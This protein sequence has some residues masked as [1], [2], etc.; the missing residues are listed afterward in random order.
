MTLAVAAARSAVLAAAG[1]S[2]NPF[3]AWENLGATATLGGTAVLAD[4]ARINAVAGTTW[5]FWRPNVTGTEAVL[6]MV[7]GAAVSVGFAAVAAHNIA[8][9]G[10]TARW[11]RSTD[12]GAI[13]GDGGAGTVTPADDTAIGW[14]MATS[15]NDAA[16]WRLR[17]T[18]LT[19]AAPLA[20]GVAFIG[21]EMVFPQRCYQGI[22]PPIE[23]TRLEG[24]V[25]VS[26]GGHLLGSDSVLKGGAFAMALEHLPDTFIRDVPFRAFLRHWNLRRAAFVHWRPGKYPQDLI[27]AWREG[28]AIMPDN[29]GPK[30][31]M[32]VALD[33]SYYAG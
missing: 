26:V 24:E 31:Y 28:A 22:R 19:A 29:S 3:V 1:Q 8:A 27:Y 32:S 10:G 33:M 23:P 11:E 30:A 25:N 9:L 13:W 5:G 4:G 14:R 21:Q 18:G 7:L 12:G 6:E 17:V 2:D 16:R 15:G 20:V